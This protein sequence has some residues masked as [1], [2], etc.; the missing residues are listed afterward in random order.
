VRREGQRD[1]HLVKWLGGQDVDASLLFCA[2]PYGLFA[3]DDPLMI[4]TVAELTRRLLDRGMHRHLDD[5]FFGGGE[6]IL[7]TALLGSFQAAVGDVDGARA[8][9]EWVM[10]QAAPNGDLPEQVSDHLL[11]P[12]RFDEWR[13]RW[14]PVATPLL[15]SHAMFLDLA[16]DLAAFA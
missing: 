4:A 11:H 6:W 7:L 3:P 12:E 2:I 8:R 10:A 13:Q 5:S 15:W 9:L 14:G 1:G 16:D